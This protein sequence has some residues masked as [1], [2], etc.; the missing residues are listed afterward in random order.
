MNSDDLYDAFRSDVVDA[1]APYLWTDDEVFR[2]MA[3]AHCRFVRNI[4]GIPD[5]SSDATRVAI[6]AGEQD[7]DLDP[8]ILR[9][10][11]AR[12]VSD[13]RQIKVINENDAAFAVG[14][15][16]GNRP[17]IYEDNSAGEVL[18]MMIGQEHGTCRWV[19]KPVA[20]DTAQLTVYRLPSDVAD[21]PGKEITDVGEEH[22]I[23]LLD[24]MKHLAYKK[25]DAETFNKSASDLGEKNFNDYCAFVKAEWNRYKHKTRVVHYGGL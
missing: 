6:V 10:M 16:Y 1:A 3:D 11:S 8:T 2:C 22:H 13:G 7:A 14:S 9:I 19:R 15:D 21:G 20:N 4:G 5:R 17:P 24:W 23:R 12:R 25:Q 18:F